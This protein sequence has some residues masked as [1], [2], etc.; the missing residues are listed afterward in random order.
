MIGSIILCNT[1]DFYQ[2]VDTYQID[3]RKSMKHQ[4]VRTCRLL[5]DYS[6]SKF[7]YNRHC[8]SETGKCISTKTVFI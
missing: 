6:G 2:Q 5:Y 7:Y 4:V 1:V 3:S 8:I